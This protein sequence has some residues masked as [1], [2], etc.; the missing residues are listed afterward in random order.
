MLALTGPL[1]AH[2]TLLKCPECSHVYGSETLLKMVPKRCNVAFEVLVF[3][4]QALFQRHRSLEEVQTEL[5][6][7]N[8]RLCASEIDYL[9]RK[10]ISYLALAHRRATPRIRQEMQMAGG[11]VLHLDA[12]HEG[13]APA[14][15]SGMDSLSQFVLDNVKIPSEHRDHIVPFLQ[16]I[17]RRYGTPTACV[18]DMGTGTCKAV[19]EVFPDVK[20][21]ICHFHF[22]RDIGKDF[23]DPAY[24]RLRNRLREHGASTGLRYLIRQMRQ[25]LKEQGLASPQLTKSLTDAQ[26]PEDRSSLPLVSAYSLALW[27]IH[28]KHSGNGYGFPF[29]RPLFQF[30]ERVL[31]LDRRLPELLELVPRDKG[32]RPLRKLANKISGSAKDPELVRAVQDLRWRAQIFDDLRKAMRIAPA[33]G[34]S[35][36]NDDGTKETMSTIRQG[37]EAFRLRLKEDPKLA[38]DLLCRKMGQQI[39]KYTEKLF[40]DPIEVD[41]PGGKVTIYPQRTNNILEQFFRGLRRAHRRKTGNNSIRRMLQAMLAETPLIKN[42]DNPEYMEILLDGKPTLEELFASLEQDPGFD[43][44]E[45]KEDSDRILPGFRSIIK[46]HSLPEQIVQLFTRTSQAA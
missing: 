43:N 42:L 8:V 4:G 13:D 37:V 2:E 32:S 33:D 26:P 11:Y 31:E 5:L 27:A 23:L 16:E 36:L 6:S 9:G 15:M 22:L 46:D 19:R 17:Q 40:A 10:F 29:D 28:G 35:G 45:S 25:R 39:D 14:L 41:T 7:R 3:V 38:N 30:A 12:T 21:F 1:T 18:H 20:D 24:R 44:R 34:T